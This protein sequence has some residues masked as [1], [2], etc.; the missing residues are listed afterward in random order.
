MLPVTKD[1]SKSSERWN[2]DQLFQYLTNVAGWPEGD[3]IAE[4]Q[5]KFERGR[6][7]VHW[8]RTD[9][10][11]MGQEGVIPAA[12]FLERKLCVARDFNSNKEHGPLDYATRGVTAGND[13][14]A[15]IK[16]LQ[17][18]IP[19]TYDLTVPAWLARSLWPPR[20]MSEM[21]E[22][23]AATSAERIQPA[24]L[25]E[26]QP[27]SSELVPSEP[28]PTARDPGDD[29]AVPT[30]KT[31]RVISLLPDLEAKLKPQMQ[32]A[33]IE[34]IVRPLYKEKFG[35]DVPSRSQIW[36]AYEKYRKKHPH[37]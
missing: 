18:S 35:G 4:M 30:T 5:E 10:E 21:S 36:R 24:A 13:G 23:P 29:D 19:A 28:V 11:G 20:L 12:S 1:P 2:V 37:S 17:A 32:P 27:A 6:L 16:V 8:R 15:F 33:E 14:R 7:P 31:D 34:K 9:L 26:L 25:L 3:A 22:A